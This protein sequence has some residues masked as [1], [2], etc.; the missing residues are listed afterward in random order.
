[1]NRQKMKHIRE[2]LCDLVKTR[3]IAAIIIS[4]QGGKL[5]FPALRTVW[6]NEDMW[7]AYQRSEKIFKDVLVMHIDPSIPPKYLSKN[8]RKLLTA[9][10]VKEDGT[11]DIHA[12]AAKALARNEALAA[13]GL[14]KKDT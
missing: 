5:V 9:G 13:A 2:I 14:P 10:A 6:R 11:I 1:M 12:I 7:G 4:A 8:H 3:R